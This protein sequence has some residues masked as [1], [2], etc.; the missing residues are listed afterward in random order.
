M[1]GIVK[2]LDFA[3]WLTVQSVYPV[4]KHCPPTE[5]LFS[6]ICDSPTNLFQEGIKG[7]RCVVRIVLDPLYGG[8]SLPGN[9]TTPI[10]QKTLSL[11]RSFCDNLICLDLSEECLQPVDLPKLF[12]TKFAGRFPQL[13]SLSLQ[14][15]YYKGFPLSPVPRVG[16]LYSPPNIQELF[17]RVF[18][19]QSRVVSLQYLNPFFRKVQHLELIG[20][21]KCTKWSTLPPCLMPNLTTLRGNAESISLLLK[22]QDDVYSFRRWIPNLSTITCVGSGTFPIQ[23]NGEPFNHE[24]LSRFVYLEMEEDVHISTETPCEEPFEAPTKIKNL[25]LDLV[26]CQIP[27][28]I[29]AKFRPC[30]N[31]TRLHFDFLVVAIRLDDFFGTQVLPFLKMFPQLKEV[32]IPANFIDAWGVSNRT[33]MRIERCCQQFRFPS[34]RRLHLC[35][36]TVYDAPPPVSPVLSANWRRLGVQF[37][38]KFLQPFQFLDTL[39]IAP[40]KNQ[41]CGPSLLKLEMAC[42]VRK[43]VLIHKPDH[44]P[45]DITTADPLCSWVPYT[46]QLK[47]LLIY[48]YSARYTDLYEAFDDAVSAVESNKSLAYVCIVVEHQESNASDALRAANFRRAVDA[49]NR[50]YRGGGAPWRWIVFISL[51]GPSGAGLCVGATS[52]NDHSFRHWFFI[53]LESLFCLVPQLTTV[54]WNDLSTVMKTN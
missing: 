5:L 17:L 47:S 7:T 54:F 10:L 37:L 15:N 20:A 16:L 14:I 43:L 22:L 2:Y 49:W 26:N 34:V 33:R 25:R 30:I 21:E 19:W 45:P 12:G 31:V 46:Q 11:R 35:A 41:F 24:A 50:R 9:G 27:S 13:L 44:S 51:C 52:F 32:I 53:K 40:V 1:R 8:S 28:A 23:Q 18:A 6:D 29:F 42:R 3:S 48:T 39:I 4:W 36:P 38:P